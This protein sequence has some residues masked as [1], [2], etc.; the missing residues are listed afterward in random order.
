MYE[1][2]FVIYI[3]SCVLAYCIFC[4]WDKKEKCLFVCFANKKDDKLDDYRFN[5][6]LLTYIKIEHQDI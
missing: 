3:Y 1:F 5:N 4:I 6:R 2:I